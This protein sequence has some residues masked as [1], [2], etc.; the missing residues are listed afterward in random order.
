MK[1]NENKKLIFEDEKTLNLLDAFFYLLGKWKVMVAAAVILAVL[2]GGLS[3]VKSNREYQANLEGATGEAKGI[4]LSEEELDAYRAKIVKIEEY[5]QNVEERDY[6]LENSIAVKL[7]PNGFYEGTATYIFSA[8][9]SADALKALTFCK[10]EALKEENFAALAKELSETVDP[11]MLREVLFFEENQWVTDTAATM[12]LTLKAQH[13]TE[14]DC[15]KMISFMTGILDD[16]VQAVNAQGTSAEVVSI[17]AF[18]CLVSDAGKMYTSSDMIHAR[19]VDYDN[20][21]IAEEV[22]T[23]KEKAFYEQEQKAE[24]TEE[25]AV[26]EE[27][28]PES[29]KPS[30]SMK[31][32]IVGAAA[33]VFLAAAYYAVLYL[34]GGKVHNKEELESWLAVPVLNTEKSM[35]V[36]AAMLAEMAEKV[37]AKKL[38]LTGSLENVVADAAEE[39]RTALAAKNVEVIL[40][41]GGLNTADALQQM[42]DCGFVTFV[43]KC[44]ESKEKEIREEIVKASSCGVKILGIVLEK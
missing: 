6:Y 39:I 24:D 17:E 36:T 41:A 25:D 33:G 10:A 5:K 4:E 43:E 22:L 26:L 23:E 19:S 18:I 27:T 12:S 42:T 28:L 38:Y 15:E 1:M 7:D 35:D 3:F 14:A 34:F 37:Q 9:N 2:A 20:L 11:A 13:Y 31:L 29:A 8:N 16:A 30:V 32:V 40:G 44:N 21:V